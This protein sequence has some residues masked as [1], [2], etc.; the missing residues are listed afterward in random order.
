MMAHTAKKIRNILLVSP[1]MPATSALPT[2]PLGLL[3]MASFL[4]EHGYNVKVADFCVSRK[5]LS[6]YLK[7][8]TPDVVGAT[9]M[10][11]MSI[12]HCI[13]LS[14]YF[15]EL[16]IPFVVGGAVPTC[17]PE[18]AL[19]EGVVD[20]IILREGES[21]FLE[22]LQKLEKG[23]DGHDVAGL[24]YLGDDGKVVINPERPQQDLCAL[25]RLDF[26]FVTPKAYFQHYPGTARCLYLHTSKGCEGNCGFCF[27]P[28]FNKSI[29]RTRNA[30]TVCEEIRELVTK[31]NADGF[32]FCDA[33]FGSDKEHL[34]ELCAKLKAVNLPFT[35]G[36]QMRI[37]VSREELQA[38]YDAGCRSIMFGVETGS[39]KM[40]KKINKNLDLSAVPKHF[41]DCREI[42]IATIAGI[43]L[44]LPGE[45]EKELQETIDLCFRMKPNITAMGFFVPFPTIHL[46]DEVFNAG[47]VTMPDSLMGYLEWFT[48]ESGNKAYGDVPN[49]ELRVVQNF[50][51]FISAVIP[52]TE[53]T[54]RFF[55]FK[56]YLIDILRFARV[57]GFS[58]GLVFAVA[59]Y[60]EAAKMFWYTFAYPKIRKKYGLYLKN[61]H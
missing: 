37:G 25:P 43:V 51:R 38:M 11:P 53:A 46:W 40:Q 2:L 36:C 52:Q 55:L 27:N 32:Y 13:E 23:E 29:H 16:R 10:S 1:L 50:F 57:R 49:K 47:K 6:H 60:W 9:M 41:D 20:F 19:I 58:S 7:N 26:S 4:K 17:C 48:L 59:I 5:K 22:L 33:H 39:P 61:L 28:H 35:W 56:R 21:T 15:K 31:Y 3:A 34:L 18:P 45:G 44:G 12:P 24:A 8:F 54:G 14:R 30:D 42:G